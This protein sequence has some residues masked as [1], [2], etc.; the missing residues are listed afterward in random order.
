MCTLLVF[1]WIFSYKKKRLHFFCCFLPLVSSAAT[2]V[3]TNRK[4]LHADSSNILPCSATLCQPFFVWPGQTSRVFFQVCSPTWEQNTPHKKLRLISPPFS[5]FRTLGLPPS[6][7]PTPGG[8]WKPPGDQLHRAAERAGSPPALPPR[9]IRHRKPD[10]SKSGGTSACVAAVSES[11][12]GPDV[13]YLLF[14]VFYFTQSTVWFDGFPCLF[15]HYS[16]IYALGRWFHAEYTV[17]FQI[18]ENIQWL[19]GLF[20]S[21]D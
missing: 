14:T 17:W 4:E 15:L 6:P 20:W 18:R 13:L 16:S 1:P 19:K 21:G 11:S 12:C 9:Q 3:A 2:S 5:C 10:R 7:A 8:V